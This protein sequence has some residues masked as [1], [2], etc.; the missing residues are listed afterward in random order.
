MELGQRHTLFCDHHDNCRYVNT[1]VIYSIHHNSF[2]FVNTHIV[3][4]IHYENCRYV[5]THVIYLIHHK[6]CRYV[7]TTF[8]TSPF[9]KIYAYWRAL[10]CPILNG[11]FVSLSNKIRGWISGSRNPRIL[12][13]F[14]IPKSRDYKRIMPGF[15]DYFLIAKYMFL[16]CIWQPF[17]AIFREKKVNKVQTLLVIALRPLG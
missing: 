5:S 10:N 17:D 3:Y 16:K 8:Y 13:P 9:N 11:L 7:N 6:N 14:S 15:S 12:D 1:L 4:V 2:R